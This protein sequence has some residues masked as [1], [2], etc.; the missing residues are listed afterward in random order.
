MKTQPPLQTALSIV[1]VGLAALMCGIGVGRFALTPLLPLMQLVGVVNLHQGAWLALAN[2]IGYLVG[3]LVWSVTLPVPWKAVRAGLVAVSLLTLAMAA[4][5]GLPIWLALRFGA[6]VA[7]AYVLIGVSAWAVSGL[8]RLARAAWSGWVYAGVG[9][10][11]L[12]AGIVGLA[13][14]VG[15]HGYQWGW[16][17]LGA[18][19]LAMTACIWPFIGGDPA[20]RPVVSKATAAIDGRG[21]HLIVSYAICGFGYIIPATFLP[22]IAHEV[23]ANPAVFG[24][25]WPAFGVTAAAS[26]IFA[27]RYFAHLSPRMVLAGGQVVMA[28]GVL[29][30]VAFRGVGPL[31]FEAL[32]VGGSFMVVTMA[33]IQEAQRLAGS[34]ASKLIG[35]LSAAFAVGQLAGPLVIALIAGHFAHTF[36]LPSVLGAG[37]LCASA[38]SLYR[39]EI[40][41]VPGQTYAGN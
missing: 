30:P 22:T 36:L 1:I 27:S 4:T 33:G 31:L 13:A 7:S 17:V 28:L 5:A 25:L 24:C 15:G 38:L 14:G 10:G 3:A 16:L 29:T 2:Y 34:G 35:A 11:M 23:I 20:I 8:A 26:T 41:A 19:S 21:A 18:T 32:C 40:V 12:L 9:A 39:A 37:L 6:G